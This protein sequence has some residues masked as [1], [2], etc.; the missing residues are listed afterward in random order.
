MSEALIFTPV[1][2]AAERYHYLRGA[3]ARSFISQSKMGASIC[4]LAALR[5]FRLMRPRGA[6]RQIDAELRPRA[7]IVYI[8]THYLIDDSFI[9]T[10]YDV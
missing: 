10:P 7:I 2:L 4:F 6:A 3:H 1:L 9:G 8:N 5:R